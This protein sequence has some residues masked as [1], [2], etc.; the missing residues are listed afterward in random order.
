MAKAARSAQWQ[1][2][3]NHCGYVGLSS[4]FPAN[5][6]SLRGTLQRRRDGTGRTRTMLA[7][8]INDAQLKGEGGN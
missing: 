3:T 2:Y 6:P 1:K 8:G 7:K 4:P 5:G